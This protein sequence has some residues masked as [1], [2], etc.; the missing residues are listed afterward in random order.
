MLIRG[1]YGKMD[2]R[3]E[4]IWDFCVWLSYQGL[5]YET[6]YYGGSEDIEKLIKSYLNDDE[7]HK[8]KEVEE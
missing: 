8:E 5:A 7:W 3:F 6:I 2:K 4:I 1:G